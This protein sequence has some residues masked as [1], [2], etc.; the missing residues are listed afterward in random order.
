MPQSASSWVISPRRYA[1]QGLIEGDHAVLCRTLHQL[2][3]LVDLALEDQI[4]T[5]GVLSMTSMMA[6]RPLPS[7]A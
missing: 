4:E 7:G 2:L 6:R 3:E 1:S 5:S